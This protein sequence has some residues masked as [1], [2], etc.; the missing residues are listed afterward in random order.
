MVGFSSEQGLSDFET[1]GIV[2]LFR[3]SQKSE[4]AALCQPVVADG[5]AGQ[6]DAISG[7]ALN[8]IF[9]EFWQPSFS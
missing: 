9:A 7:W 1:A 4:D 6:A 3:G 5:Y 2:K 8:N